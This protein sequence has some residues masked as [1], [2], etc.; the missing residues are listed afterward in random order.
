MLSA[1][2]MMKRIVRQRLHVFR[3]MVFSFEAALYD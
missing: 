1:P 2:T 3:I